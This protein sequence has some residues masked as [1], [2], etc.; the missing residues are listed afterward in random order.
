MTTLALTN[1]TSDLAH[2]GAAVATDERD[3]KKRVPI[4]FQLGWTVAVLYTDVPDASIPR[5]QLRSHHELQSRD[6][7]QLEMARLKSL[8]NRLNGDRQPYASQFK[9]KLT[10]LLDAWEEDRERYP[11]SPSDD[12]TRL[13]TAALKNALRAFHLS[14]LT[15]L[16]KCGPEEEL[17][18]ELGRSLR[19]TVNP[20]MYVAPPSSGTARRISVAQRLCMS[21]RRGRVARVQ[22]WLAM[23][24][25]HFPES[26]AKIVSSSLGRWSDLTE[27]ALVKGGPG[28]LLGFSKSRRKDFAKK[29]ENRLLPQGDVWLA[30]LIG[31]QA[32][33]ELLSPEGVVAA[34]DASLRRTSRL[35]RK[36]LWRY[37]WAL[38][39]LLLILGGI[40]LV[41]TAML[42]G[43]GQVIT[44]I[45]VAA[46]GLG[47]TWKGVAVALSRV[48]AKAEAPIYGSE[49]V[50]A[51]AWSVTNLP[52]A[53]V[54]PR[55]VRYLRLAGAAK[56]TPLGA[57]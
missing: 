52:K 57:I 37:K 56:V 20:P 23:L 8:V 30:L 5:D 21:L 29:L 51:M 7:I 22:E 36:V 35:I 39:I 49:K 32:T 19:D 54:T 6:R 1:P 42:G 26:A 27:V 47:I 4:C 48:A 17:A 44:L 18:Y 15:Q 11:E 45:G 31:T 38:L 10:L 43:V 40:I 16:T 34:A 53:K 33:D 46:S 24:A 14:V 50:E 9:P 25:P 12:E 55:G 3:L 41:S 28:G 2:N 13:R